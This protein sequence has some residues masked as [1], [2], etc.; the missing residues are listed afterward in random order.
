LVCKK[1]N[2]FFG[3]NRRKIN[4]KLLEINFIKFIMKPKAKGENHPKK[5]KNNK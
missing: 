5:E 3:E 4:K 1:V 2:V